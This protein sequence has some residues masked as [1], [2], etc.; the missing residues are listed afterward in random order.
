MGCLGA[1]GSEACEGIA[2]TV[3]DER[4]REA[5]APWPLVSFLPDGVRMGARPNVQVVGP[6]RLDPPWL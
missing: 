4:E 5:A 3:K 2:I 1:T 6:R